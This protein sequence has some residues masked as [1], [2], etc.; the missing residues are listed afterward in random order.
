[1]NVQHAKPATTGATATT[2][3][4]GRYTHVTSLLSMEMIILIP[5][6][7]ETSF[8]LIADIRKTAK[9]MWENAHIRQVSMTDNMSGT[10]AFGT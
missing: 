6:G 5:N 10:L 2:F 8:V 7:F 1:M 4:C 3:P 9:H